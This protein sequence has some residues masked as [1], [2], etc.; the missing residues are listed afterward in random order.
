MNN[1]EILQFKYEIVLNYCESSSTRLKN[2][3]LNSKLDSNYS[4]A[5][6]KGASDAYKKM[7]LS[8]SNIKYKQMDEKN[9]KLEIQKLVISYELIKEHH[10]LQSKETREPYKKGLFDGSAVAYKL[11]ISDL[12]NFLI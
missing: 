6:K 3:W 5:L 11:I 7:Y 10:E 12:K 8:M 4:S 2:S 9:L 1:L